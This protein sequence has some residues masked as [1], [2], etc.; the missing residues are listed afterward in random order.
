M[1]LPGS[2][3]LVAVGL[4]GFAFAFYLA[5]GFE[6]VASGSD[7]LTRDNGYIFGIARQV[8]AGRLPYLDFP[9]E[10][11]PLSL[12]PIALP[13][14]AGGT[15]I[16]RWYGVLVLENVALVA[17]TAASVAYLAR[18]GWSA[19]GTADTV[20]VYALLVAATPILFIRFDAL[21]ALLST[22]ALCAAVAGRHA[23]AG[24][25][26]A[27]GGL[28]KLY[29]VLL[30]PLFALPGLVARR[31]RDVSSLVVGAV[32]P[33]VLGG[34]SLFALT[35]VAA[36]SFVTYHGARGVEI[37]SLPASVALVAHLLGVTAAS[38]SAGF[39]SWQLDSPIVTSLGWLWI[40]I[41]VVL[42]A[43][44]A[45]SAIVRFADDTRATGSVAPE[46][47][48][49]HLVAAI[50]V[51]M[52][53]Y[54]VLSPQYMVWLLPFAA[55][56]PRAKV[57]AVGVACLLTLY[58]Y[59]F[60]AAGLIAMSPFSIV[61]LALRNGLLLGIFAWLVAPGLAAAVRLRT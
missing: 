29:P 31:W 8:A 39:G 57:I 13:Y 23:L 43:A 5:L 55:L 12:I 49:V 26:L 4:A 52:L 3:R 50:L 16:N 33:V 2:W 19:R 6:I 14:L 21:A 32:V 37:E 18:R 22:L 15:D 34:V 10:Y 47:H 38:T 58:L 59:P 27:V 53:G 46:T 35:G 45:V 28:A 30:L 7:V 44:V 61:V 11:P 9:F 48:I 40:G 56:L 42:A 20:L 25:S 1:N 51:F 36:F 41:P 24:L 60:G 54:R 17:A